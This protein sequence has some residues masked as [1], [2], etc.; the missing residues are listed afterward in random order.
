[1]DF[2]GYMDLIEQAVDAPER[3]HAIRADVAG[4]S[5]LDESDRAFALA[6]IGT[7]L[8]DGEDPDAIE[9]EDDLEGADASAG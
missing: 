4:D 6:T 7:Y 5:S 8:A 2:G 1:M 3:L 9:D